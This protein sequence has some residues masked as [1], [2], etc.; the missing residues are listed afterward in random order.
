MKPPTGNGELPRLRSVVLAA[1]WTLRTIAF[2]AGLAALTL[3]LVY[4]DRPP[5]VTDA[6]VPKVTLGNVLVGL[7]TSFGLPLLLPSRWLRDRRLLAVLL[8]LA[9]AWVLPTLRGDDRSHGWL[10][11]AF[12]SLVAI[13]VM[14][15]WNICHG[16]A[17][18]PVRPPADPANHAP[19][20][21][22]GP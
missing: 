2:A 10:L 18:A 5:T 6:E 14:V 17:A 15:L 21:G 8:V 13:A 22:S 11:R 1:L 4:H 9:V 20:Q 19:H 12:A 16:L 3:A 7:A